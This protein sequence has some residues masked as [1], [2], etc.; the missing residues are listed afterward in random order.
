MINYKCLRYMMDGSTLIIPEVE[1]S[2]EGIYTC[3][4][5]TTLDVAEASGSIT[6]VGTTL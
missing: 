1:E 5:I 6:I 3:E 4:V 2:D